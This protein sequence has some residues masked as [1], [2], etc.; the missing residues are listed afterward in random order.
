M[1]RARRRET[2]TSSVSTARK[3]GGQV[4]ENDEAVQPVAELT[5]E[6][7]KE[8]AVVTVGGSITRNLGD[9][10][11]CRVEVRLAMPCDPSEIDATYI[12][13]SEWVDTH[14]GQE[15]DSATGGQ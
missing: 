6:G 1:S 15:L 2:A 4:V 8:P 12:K 3:V 13:A 7:A 14:L 11:S 5:Y 10:N 9:F